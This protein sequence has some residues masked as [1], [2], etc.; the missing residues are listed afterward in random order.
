MVLGRGRV[1]LA[2]PCCLPR[3]CRAARSGCAILLALPVPCCAVL[4]AA[5]SAAV[6]CAA[7]E[8]ARARSCTRTHTRMHM[9]TRMRTHAAVHDPDRCTACTLQ[10]PRVRSPWC[11]HTQPRT[12]CARGPTPCAPPPP[13]SSPQ[14][15]KGQRARR[16]HLLLFQPG[17]GRG[18]E[19]GHPQEGP[20][21]QKG[22]SSSG[23]R[24]GG[25]AARG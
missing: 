6:G 9:C 24:G 1:G 15:G 19:G 25:G 16:H 5:A 11:M 23:R 12:P 14:G 17:V 7:H 4:L 18:Q 8:S 21:P 20:H 13:C 10:R 3:L 2:V 22:S